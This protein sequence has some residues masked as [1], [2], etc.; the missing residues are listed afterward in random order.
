MKWRVGDQIRCIRR[1]GQDKKGLPLQVPVVG[2][3]YTVTAF[4][5]APYGTGVKLE[6][7]DPSPYN[8]YLLHVKSGPWGKGIY[9]EIYLPEFAAFDEGLKRV[10][11]MLK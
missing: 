10:E 2:R 11:E 9:F 1:P 3:V 8:G 7:L 5:Q 6:G 4:Y